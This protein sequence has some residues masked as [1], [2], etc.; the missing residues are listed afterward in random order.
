MSAMR[1][2]RKTFGAALTSAAERDAA[3]V[4]LSVDSG[5][6]SGLGQLR[7]THPER[8][9]EVGIMEQAATGMAS[10]LAT[11]GK[12]PVLCAIAPFVTARNFEMFRN[13]LGYMRQNVKIVGRNAGLSYSQLG[14][15]H[16]SLDDIALTRMIP[17]V[18]VIAPQDCGEIEG[19]VQAMLRHDGPVYMRIGAGGIPD[20][21][22]PGPF[23]IGRG[24]VITEGDHVTVVSTGHVTAAVQDAVADLRARGIRAEHI[25]M[26]TIE[27]LDGELLL[28][29]ISRTGRIV[30][31]EEHYERGGLGGA[32]AELLSKTL[33]AP[34]L[35]IGVPHRFVPSGPYEDVLE[36][37]GLDVRSLTDR[38]AAFAGEEA[39]LVS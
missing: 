38:I 26:P 3:I 23:K 20:L 7:A 27:P 32:V 21:F 6:S 29:S 28:A 36:A 15:T 31:V 24:R 8:Y 2:P 14:P 39:P 19:A 13:D 11:A 35:V 37:C 5:L 9:I 18:V 33:R 34:H 10:G 22:P 25:G 4:A 16:H 30:T 1:D 17:G 12:V